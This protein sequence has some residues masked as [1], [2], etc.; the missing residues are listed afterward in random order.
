MSVSSAQLFYSRIR[1]DRDLRKRL[2]L[3]SQQEELNRCLKSEGFE[4]SPEELE[5]AYTISLTNC[6]SQSLALELKELL[7][8]YQ[9]LS[10]A[11]AAAGLPAGM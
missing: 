10:G 7:L 5:Q 6:Q 2:N 8:W 9:M 3:C 1:Q 11:V 4:F